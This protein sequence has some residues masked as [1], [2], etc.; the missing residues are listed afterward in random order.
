M[1]VIAWRTS[2]GR[3]LGLGNTPYDQAV[4]NIRVEFVG[5]V[6]DRPQ[7]PFHVLQAGAKKAA[8]DKIFWRHGNHS[9]VGDL[10]SQRRN[11][12]VGSFWMTAS[13]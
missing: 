3:T 10:I 9:S 4:I 5:R 6:D 8:Y 13:N 11:T 1:R 12:N 2:R 7:E